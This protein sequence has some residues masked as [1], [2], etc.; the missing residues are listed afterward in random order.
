MN[1]ETKTCSK[2]GCQK[3]L[4]EFYRDRKWYHG[5]C[6]QCRREYQRRYNTEHPE[7][8][9]ECCLKWAVEHP[10]QF[11]E[12][13][14][15]RA[16]KHREQNRERGQ[17]YYDE[18]PERWQTYYQ[19]PEGKLSR[20]NTRH[21]RRALIKG[22]KITLAE[23]TAIKEQQGFRCYWCKRKFKDEELMDHSLNKGGLQ[24]ATLLL[25]VDDSSKGDRLW[26]L[27]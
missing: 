7:Q 4:S 22:G 18:H 16:T 8:V 14:R 24:V 6:K 1:T 26:S 21:N 5:D 17:K 27:I 9:R 15:K 10:E 11:K 19:T 2:C 25:L 3:P 20:K 23:W 13:S 12:R